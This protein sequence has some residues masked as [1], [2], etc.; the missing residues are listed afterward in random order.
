MFI[1]RGGRDHHL[2]A[3]RLSDPQYVLPSWVAMSAFG[4]FVRGTTPIALNTPPR[5]TR[6]KRTM[7][8]HLSWKAVRRRLSGLL[9]PTLQSDCFVP[10]GTAAIARILLD[11]LIALSGLCHPASQTRSCIRRRY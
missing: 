3:G 1:A 7:W 2:I 8:G 11:G 4:P 10:W 9:R 6:H 5:R